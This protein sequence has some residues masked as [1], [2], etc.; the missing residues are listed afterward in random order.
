MGKEVSTLINKKQTAGTYDVSFNAGNLSS[1]VY[2]YS[3]FADGII[4]DTKRMLMIK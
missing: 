2:F 4:I 3:L 1:G